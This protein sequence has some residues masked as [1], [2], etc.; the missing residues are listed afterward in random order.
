MESGHSYLEAD[1]M[2][3]TIERAT[4]HLR[5]FTTRERELAIG[6]AHKAS[7]PFCVKLFFHTDFV[8]TK[9]LAFALITN[10]SRKL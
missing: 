5:I 7:P 3:S 8:D 2:H 6:G 4:K 10:R 9:I 1:S